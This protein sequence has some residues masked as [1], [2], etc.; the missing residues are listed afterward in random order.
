LDKSSILAKLK[1]L[2]SSEFK[3]DIESIRAE[4]HLSDDLHLDSLDLVDL[5]LSLSDNIKQK[6][7]PGLF[8]EAG[9]VQDLIDCLQP[10]W[11]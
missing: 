3:L 9:T 7:D 4:S 5:I 6:I 10:V 11:K 8:K 1:E 2:M